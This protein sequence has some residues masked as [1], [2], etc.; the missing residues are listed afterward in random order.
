M[1]THPTACILCS[2]NCGLLVEVKDGHLTKIRGNEAHPSSRGYLCE[3]AASLDHYQNHAERL[4]SP[5]RRRADGSFEEISWDTAIEKVAARL[6][7]L[8]ELHGPHCLAFYGGAGQGNHLALPYAVSFKMALGTPYHYH[9]LGQEKTGDF[10]LDGHLYGSQANHTTNDIENAEVVV[11]SG[12][13]P[14]R[15]HGFPRTRQVLKEIAADPGRTMVVVDPRRTHTAKMADVHFQVRPGTDAFLFAAML[16]TLVQEDLVDHGFLDRRTTGYTDV[17]GPLR[18]V[19]VDRYAEAAGV[20]AQLVRKTARRLASASSVS[21]RSDLG[22]QQSR[23]STLNLYLEKLLYLLTGHFGK[24]GGMNIHAHTIPLLWHSDPNAPDW[25]AQLTRVNAMMP[26]AGFYPPNLVPSEILSEKPERLRGVF[27]DSANP[28]VTSADTAAQREAF[29]K[30]ELLVAIDTSFT[31]TCELA[32]YVLPAAS[33]FEKYDCTF[34]NWGFPENHLHV[35]HPLFQPYADTLPEQE[36][37]LRLMK[38]IGT[39]FEEHPLAG[40]IEQMK[41][42]P[43]LQAMPEAKRN[44]TAPLLLASHQ[45]AERHR[46]AV[47]RAGIL[48]SGE[49]LAMALYQRIVESPSGAVISRHEYEDSFSFLAHPDGRIHLAV[50]LMLDWLG[51]LQEEAGNEPSDG[52]GF[53]FI[54]S[55]GERR[56]SN[57]TTNFRDPAWRRNDHEGNL[58]MH[59]GDAEKL[60]LAK[61]DTVVVASKRGEI[62]AQVRIDDSVLPG[63]VTLPHGFGLKFADEDGERRPHGPL[64]NLLTD[65]EDCDPLCKTPYHKNTPV[66]IRL[67]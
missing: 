16:A 33:Q 57:A 58:R 39:R 37:Y 28:V 17:A 54:L 8:R 3:K 10:W 52:A 46:E 60:G 19:P 61:G 36:I 1:E 11:F 34:F 66:R 6:L 64:I 59:P 23:H 5:L 27:V 14:W 51:E 45:F 24:K 55:A 15:A 13:N 56:S 32:H 29:S 7:S 42:H 67:A 53:P 26:I 49:G 21:V 22:L 20:D 9:A 18:S 25:E 2:E 4:R 47:L 65:L 62:E 41:L 50:P 35:R 40:P 12:T 31:E 38:A 63:V 30:L 48:D 43:Y 44:A